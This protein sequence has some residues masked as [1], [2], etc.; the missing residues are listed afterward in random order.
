MEWLAL[1]NM[2]LNILGPVLQKWL[3]NLLNRAAKDMP[4][5]PHQYASGAAAERNLWIAAERILASERRASVWWNPLTWGPAMA[6]A[7]KRRYFDAARNAAMAREGQ[8]YAAAQAGNPR[9][10]TQ[11]SPVEIRAIEQEG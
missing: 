4:L 3:E 1:V 7:R 2:I 10:V 9:L 6:D 5:A 8:F 11:L